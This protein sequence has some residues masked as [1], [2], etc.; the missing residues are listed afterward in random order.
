MFSYNVR[1]PCLFCFLLSL[2]YFW[3][4]SIVLVTF[5][6]VVRRLVST[7]Q[8]TP[9]EEVKTCEVK[10]SLQICNNQRFMY[11]LYYYLTRNWLWKT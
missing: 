2:L 10:M 4:P 7:S 1:V 5:V 9:V 8:Y 6:T 3:S 11:L